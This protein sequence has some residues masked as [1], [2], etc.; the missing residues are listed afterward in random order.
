MTPRLSTSA[1]TTRNYHGSGQIV[2]NDSLVMTRFTGGFFDGEGKVKFYLNDYQGNNIAVIDANGEIVETMGY[3]PY[4]M[5]WDLTDITPYLFAD[6]EYQHLSGLDEYIHGV[7]RSVPYACAFS[8]PDALCEERTWDS[9][10]CFCSSNPINISDPSGL[11]PIYS[12]TGEFLGTDDTGLQGDYIVME[13]QKFQQGMS[14]KKAQENALNTDELSTDVLDLI[15]SHFSNLP[16]RPDYDGVLTLEEANEWFKNGEG[17]PLFVDLSKLT[18]PFTKIPKN[19][20]IGDTFTTNLLWSSFL[21]PNDGLVFG[22]ITLRR[23][24]Q[25]MVEGE[26]DT[27]DFDQHE[28]NSLETRVRNQLTKVGAK[29]A[30]EGQPYPINFYGK[31]RLKVK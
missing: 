20:K 22:S 3:Y 6:K 12:S 4:G 10:Y 24:S 30:G 27:Y 13:E 9:P 11:R 21:C 28:G 25:E 8:T 1:T 29:V 2:E 14:S 5:P 19:L 18:M 17:S 26:P 16:N 15:T 23:V 7:R 31:K